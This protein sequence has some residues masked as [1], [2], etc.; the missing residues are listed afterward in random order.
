MGLTRFITTGSSSEPFKILYMGRDEFSCSV[1]KHLHDAKDVWQELHIATHPDEH[2][3]RRGSQLSVSPLKTLGQSLG[4]PIY[5]I[6]HAKP[7]FKAW[8]VNAPPSSQNALTSRN[9]PSSQAT[10]P[11]SHM[12]LTASFGRI[13]PQRMLAAF[14][15]H[16]RLNV[17]PSPL[18]AYRGA[19]P[20]QHMLMAGEKDTAVCVIEML[21]KVDAGA[22][23]GRE[24]LAI[25]PDADFAT[26][27]DLL[28]DVGG[29]LLVRVLREK[30]RGTASSVAQ[31]ED[32]SAPRAPLIQAADAMLDFARMSAEDIVRLQRAIGHQVR[33]RRALDDVADE[34]ISLHGLSV[35]GEAPAFLTREPGGAMLHKP[36]RKILVRCAGGTVLGARE[37]KMQDKAQVGAVDWW[38]GAQSLGMVADRCVRLSRPRTV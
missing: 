20:I 18:P 26:M 5:E 1:F 13:I 33:H 38:N 11:P 32:V 9:A 14:P 28:G 25:P 27:R 21:R 3:G 31:A 7:E 15:P 35:E 4:V 37:A 10:P 22:V 30:M 23:W 8:N 16:N 12:L 19:A 29:R 24:E 17:H 34:A 2:V 36:G 6:P